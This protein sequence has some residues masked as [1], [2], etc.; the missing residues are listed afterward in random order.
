M[1]PELHCDELS[2]CL[3]SPF[4]LALFPFT[5]LSDGFLKCSGFGRAITAPMAVK[6]FPLIHEF[7]PFFC[8]IQFKG[9]ALKTKI[10]QALAKDSTLEITRQA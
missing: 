4:S 7:P 8:R 9:I 10:L 1:H 6:N 3:L 2:P 5:S